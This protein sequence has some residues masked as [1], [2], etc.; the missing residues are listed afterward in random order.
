VQRVLID[1]TG[2]DE[3]D[4]L[5]EAPVE[6][7]EQRLAI[8]VELLEDDRLFTGIGVG[9][10]DPFL[11]V[12]RADDEASPAASQIPVGLGLESVA[13]GVGVQV[14]VR[15]EPLVQRRLVRIPSGP[16]AQN[17]EV[18]A[19]EGHAGP[20]TV[21]LEDLHATDTRLEHG[22]LDLGRAGLDREK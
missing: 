4:V 1:A 12:G 20:R 10:V 22:S 2:K 17:V 13:L 14:E 15:D 7:A 3:L 16:V 19:C 11:G 18:R 9:R 21:G 8:G 5:V 6:L